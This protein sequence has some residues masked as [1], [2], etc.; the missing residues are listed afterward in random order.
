KFT[1]AGATHTLTLQVGGTST[2]IKTSFIAINALDSTYD[3]K[4][5]ANGSDLTIPNGYAAHVHIDGSSVINSYA[6]LSV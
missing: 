4:I 6:S 1:G 5:D 2:G 3:L